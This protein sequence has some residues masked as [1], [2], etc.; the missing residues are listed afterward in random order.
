MKKWTEAQ[1]RADNIIC[2]QDFNLEYSQYKSV[3][4][5]GLDRTAVAAGT[6]TYT[7][8]TQRAFMQAMTFFIEEPPD[9][10]DNTQLDIGYKCLTFKTYAGGYQQV[11]SFS[12]PNLKDGMVQIEMGFMVFCNGWNTSAGTATTASSADSAQKNIFVKLDWNGET[13]LVAGPISISCKSVR[14]AASTFTTGGTGTLQI[15]MRASSG[16]S[17]DNDTTSMYLIY[18]VNG[19]VLGRWR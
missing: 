6:F 2:S 5:G 13:I 18:N 12:V 14:V 3:I 15:Y 8:C 4:N 11:G 7:H 17:G 19:L 1:P 10:L 16:K 9:N